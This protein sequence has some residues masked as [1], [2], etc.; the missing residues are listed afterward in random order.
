M[1]EDTLRTFVPAIWFMVRRHVVVQPLQGMEKGVDVLAS[2][3]CIQ[4]VY[5]GPSELYESRAGV[6]H[7]CFI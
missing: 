1:F 3:V 4:F 5:L 7:L 2:G 6:S